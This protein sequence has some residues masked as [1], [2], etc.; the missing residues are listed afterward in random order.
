MFVPLAA[1]TLHATPNAEMRRYAGADVAVWRTDLPPSAAG[2]VHTIDREQVVVV[3][4][5][6]LT[7]VV[8]GETLVVRPGDAVVLAGG[9]VRQLRNEGVDRVVTLTSALPGALA[10]VADGEPVSV[11]WAG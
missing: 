10:R 9:V 5:G 2:P 3:I 1:T 11:P 4:D 7:A 6:E 8:A